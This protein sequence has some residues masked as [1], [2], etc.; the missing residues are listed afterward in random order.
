MG[1][2]GDSSV[3]IFM[4]EKQKTICNFCQKNKKTLIKLSIKAK[5]TTE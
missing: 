2:R 5:T 4:R 3:L 1:T